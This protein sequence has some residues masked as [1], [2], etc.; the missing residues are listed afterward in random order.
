MICAQG[1]AL[2]FTRKVILKQSL[3]NEGDKTYVCDKLQELLG[4]IE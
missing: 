1:S 3:Q 2:S 4:S